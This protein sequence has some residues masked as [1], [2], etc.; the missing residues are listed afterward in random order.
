MHLKFPF[1]YPQKF[2]SL[3]RKSIGLN[4]AVSPDYSAFVFLNELNKQQEEE[5]KKGDN[6]A[7][8]LSPSR[9]P[10]VS[11]FANFNDISVSFPHIEQRKPFQ[12]IVPVAKVFKPRVITPPL[13]ESSE[14]KLPEAKCCPVTKS[15]MSVYDR[16]GLDR[17]KTLSPNLDMF[18]SHQVS[19]VPADPNE[20][21]WFF[22]IYEKVVTLDDNKCFLNAFSLLLLDF[23]VSFPDNQSRIHGL[24][25]S[26]GH[27][28]PPL[29]FDSETCQSFDTQ[30]TLTNILKPILA[31]HVEHWFHHNRTQC[32]D[33]YSSKMFILNDLFQLQDQSDDQIIAR[34]CDQIKSSDAWLGHESLD[35]I[36]DLFSVHQIIFHPPLNGEKGNNVSLFVYYHELKEMRA[37]IDVDAPYALYNREGGHWTFCKKKDITDAIM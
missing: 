10:R 4:H 26:L 21:H 30:A 33:E 27:D 7:K 12:P 25:G 22:D 36:L 31:D 2:K 3:L 18:N 8:N 6:Q 9:I 28:V 24:L 5:S 20:T 15:D 1:L 37:T 29:L 32:P 17:P 16:Y 23:G 13:D 35:F 19:V 34:Y 14:T 11:T